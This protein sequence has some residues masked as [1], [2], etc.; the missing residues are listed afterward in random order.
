[1]GAV[2]VAKDLGTCASNVTGYM[3]CPAVFG[4]LTTLAVRGVNR[5]W[6]LWPEV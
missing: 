3:V 2:D 6:K 5:R 4:F 1:M